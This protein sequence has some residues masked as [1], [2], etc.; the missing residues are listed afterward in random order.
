MEGLILSDRDRENLAAIGGM[1]NPHIPV[2]KIPKSHMVGSVIADIL[3]SASSHPSVI[4]LVNNLVEGKPATP[5]ATALVEKLRALV[6]NILDPSLVR[7]PQDL[8]SKIPLMPGGLL[9]M[10]DGIFGDVDPRWGALGIRGT[11]TIEWYISFVACR[12][13]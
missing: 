9:R 3:K 5:V 4:D 6:V 12:P 8:Q 10:G 13:A 7:L 11:H 2:T 1:R